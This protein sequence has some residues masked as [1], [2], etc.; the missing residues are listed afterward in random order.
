MG[1]VEFYPQKSL[2]VVWDK[3][4][5]KGEANNKAKDKQNFFTSTET[6]FATELNK[7]QLKITQVNKCVENRQWRSGFQYT[8][9]K[10]LR[11]KFSPCQLCFLQFG[12]LIFSDW[13]KILVLENSSHHPSSMD[14]DSGP[15]SVTRPPVSNHWGLKDGALQ[16]A[17]LWT[18]AHSHGLVDQNTVSSRPTRTK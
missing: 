16:S 8:Q 3:N 9:V 4:T 10:E 12:G 1:G 11:G 13:R 6:L 2:L 18:H 14:M 7:T 5:H 17:R 15:V